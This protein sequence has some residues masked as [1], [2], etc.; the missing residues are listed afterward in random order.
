MQGSVLQ[1]HPSLHALVT[2]TLALQP[3]LSV[4]LYIFLLC[5]LLLLLITVLLAL[6]SQ[7]CDDAV[8]LELVCI[9]GVL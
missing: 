7:S 1:T 4:L 8:V 3:A 9:Q 5:L 2:C 6:C